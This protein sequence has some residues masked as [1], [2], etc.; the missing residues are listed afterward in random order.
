MSEE[1]T[2]RRWRPS[3]V[4]QEEGVKRRQ[5]QAGRGKLF[6][7]THA[8]AYFEPHAFDPAIQVSVYQTH[9]LVAERLSPITQATC[10]PS[11]PSLISRD[12][13]RSKNFRE[14]QE[15]KY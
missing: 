8:N 15:N 3:Q 5:D 11:I 9:W 7:L 12:S 1:G 13:K 4:N 2:K 14:V 6:S 10:A